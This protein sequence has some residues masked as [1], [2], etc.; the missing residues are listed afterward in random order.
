MALKALG[1]RIL[2]KPQETSKKTDA[3]MVTE[4]GIFIPDE[5]AKMDKNAQTTGTIVEIGEDAFVAF[6]PKTAYWGLKVGDKIHYPRYAGKGLTDSKTKEELL[7]I[8]D[9]DVI[10]VEV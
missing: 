5:S 8:N 9:E 6:K 2:V 7:A 4:G 1:F 10:A 3:G